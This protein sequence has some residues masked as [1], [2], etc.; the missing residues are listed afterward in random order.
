LIARKKNDHH[1][2]F[3]KEEDYIRPSL[4]VSPLQAKASVALQ[5]I[6]PKNDLEQG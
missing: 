2:G 3:L 6:P 5:L 1:L 4:I